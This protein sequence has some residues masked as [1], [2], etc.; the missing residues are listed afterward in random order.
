MQRWLK[1]A[2]YL[3]S[4]GYETHV[5]TP[6]NPDF[7][8]LDANLEKEIPS[9]V[10]VIKRPIKEPYVYYRALLGKKNTAGTNFGFTNSNKKSFAQQFAIWVRS[11]LFIPDARKWWVKPSIKFLKNYIVENNIDTVITTGPPQSM[12]LIGLGLKN[13]F[14][15]QIKWIADFRDPWTRIYTNQELMISGFAQRRLEKLEKEVLQKCDKLVTVS[16]YLKQEFEALGAKGKSHVIYNGFDEDDY[17]KEDSLAIEKDDNKKFVISY[18]GLFPALSNPSELWKSLKQMIAINPSFKEDLKIVLV[19]N[20]DNSVVVDLQEND[21]IQFVELKG[22]VSHQEAVAFQ[23]ASKLL[24]L[25]IPNVSNSKGILTGKLFEYLASEKPII[26]FGDEEGD[27]AQI[28]KETDAGK[29]FSY[30]ENEGISTFIFKTYESFKNNEVLVSNKVY[31]KFSR[32]ALT[33]QLVK[34][35]L[36]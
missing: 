10:K 20:I 2:K 5:Y 24:L 31:E 33:K 26:A 4:L 14:Q 16:D 8:V 9:E 22:I 21:L 1:F 28:L 25:C 3:P 17:R 23:K 13:E 27:V 36:D 19:G 32:L 7:A 18:I 11:N 29:L 12:H 34:N 35:L 6:E 15:D 30:Q